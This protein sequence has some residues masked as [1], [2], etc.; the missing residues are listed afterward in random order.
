MTYSRFGLALF[1]VFAMVSWLAA[2]ASAQSVVST[3]AGLVYFFEG[4][5]FLGDQALE[6]KFGRFPEVAEGGEL[7]TEKGRAEILLTPGTFLRIGDNSAVR[8]ISSKL[9]AAKV[10]LLHGSAIIE[11]NEP[12]QGTS[13]V[14][15]YKDWQVRVPDQ[16]VYRIDAE[17]S[18]VQV[19]KGQVT[20]STGSGPEDVKVNDGQFLPLAAVLVPEPSPIIRKE[21][22]FTTWAMNRSQAVS[23]DNATAAEIVDDPSALDNSQL[24]LGG[25]VDPGLGLTPYGSLNGYGNL[26]GFTYFPMTL[27]GTPYGLSFW[28]PFQPRLTSIY[29]TPYVGGTLFRTGWPAGIRYPSGILR[30]PVPHPIGGN[31]GSGFSRPGGVTN[32]VPFTP[33]PAPRPVAIPRPAVAP[34]AG[35]HV[36]GH[37]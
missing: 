2:V 24:A 12:A 7:R 34:R 21:D 6:Q 28:S 32:R 22:A 11:A 23:A 8:M 30:N 9:T 19:Y 33:A 14:L 20:V 31:V 25:V 5:V 13:A 4:S 3:R 17:P 26:S 1:A 37:R 10:E 29:I 36:G 16:G 35:G 27:L 15:S 18:R